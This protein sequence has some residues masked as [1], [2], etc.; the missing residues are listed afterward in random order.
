[1]SQFKKD[2]II[3][4]TTG[5][6]SDYDVH[7]FVRAIKDFRSEEVQD[8]Y[9]RTIDSHIIYGEFISWLKEQGFIRELTAEEQPTEYH[10]ADY[11]KF[12]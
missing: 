6:Y 2:Q 5:E 9:Q 10:F 11:G 8:K 7:C 1:M 4:L 3:Y 12:T